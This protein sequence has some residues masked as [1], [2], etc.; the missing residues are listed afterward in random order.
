MTGTTMKNRTRAGDVAAAP[1]TLQVAT[2]LARAGQQ[3]QVIAAATTALDAP[4]LAPAERLTLLELRAESRLA[5]IDLA[6][7][8]TDAQAMLALADRRRSAA[9]RARA[10]ACLAHVQTRQERNAEALQTAA[11]ALEAAQRSRRPELIALARLRQATAGF[12]LQPG[13]AAEQATAAAQRFG[14]LGD[15]A[16]QGQALRVLAAVKLAQAD[17]PEHRAIAQQAVDLARASGDRSGES[18]A[19]STLFGGDLDLAQR[20]RGLHLALQAAIA[21]GDRHFEASALHNLCL[22]YNRL[23]LRHRALR[24][25]QLTS[26]MHE[27]RVR[28]AAT[29]NPL[30]IA[31]VLQADLGDAAGCRQ[32][33]AQAEAAD[34]ADPDPRYKGYVDV[35]RARAAERWGTP[36]HSVTLWRRTLAPFKAGWAEPMALALLANAEL[37]AGL[38]AAALRHAARG[39]RLL[40]QR[41][42]QPGGGSE[43]DAHILWQ[44]A[45]ALHANGRPAAAL[46][47][48]EAAYG[49]LVQGITTLSDEGLRRSYLHAPTS[50]AALV[51]A[52][53]A[54]AREQAW[55]PARYTAHLAG[56]AELR[57]SVE[58][59][60]DTGLRLNAL[61]SEA[62]L[63]EFLIEEVAELLGARRV[64]LVLGSGAGAQVAGAQLP[65]DES[66]AALLAAVAP[67]LDEA[68]RTRAIGLR[69]GPEGTDAIEQRS[70]LVAPL[71]V[72]Q[73]LLGFLYA[74]LEGLFGRFHD[75]DRDLL[76]TLAAQAAVALANLRTQEGLERTVAERT[77]QL[78]QRA[79][80]LALINSIQQ[81]LAAKLDFQGIVDLVGDKLCE[82]FKTDD[83]SI[84]WWD[85]EANT[86]ESLYSAE[87]GQHLPKRPPSPVRLGGP[88]EKLLR[89]GVGGYM[90]T[91]EEQ[92][93]KG[94]GGAAPGTD[95]ALSLMAAPI[96]GTQR[97]LG[98]IILEN[99]EREHAYGEA[100]LRVLTTIGA[101]MG[102]ALENARLFDETQRL[103]KETE[104]R[105]AELAVINSIQQAVGAA[106]DFQAIVD[107]VGDKLREVF[108]TGDLS[109]R[110]YDEAAGAV[111]DMYACEH[112]RRL[113]GRVAALKPGT[114]PHRFYTV[115]RQ[116][117]SI[118]SVEEQLARGVPVL[119]GTD[120]A[121]S[122]LVV[123]MLAG[124]RM[125][126]S[127][128]LEDHERDHAFGPAEA[129]L[130][131][132]IAS[133]MAVALL[134]AKS[135]E[136]ERQRAAE[137][138]V[139]NSIQQG[140]AATLDFQGIV[141]LV[142]DKL[143]EVLGTPNVGI[144]WHDQNSG[145]IHYL[146]EREQAR[147]IEHPPA[148]PTPGGIFETMMR[149]RQPVVFARADDGG[150]VQ[151]P[152]LAGTTTGGSSAHMPIIVG[153][154]VCGAISCT[155]YERD[156]AFCKTW[157]AISRDRDTFLAWMKQHVLGTRDHAQFMKSAGVRR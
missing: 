58:R 67:W 135:F 126:G 50:H 69:H 116:T 36:R 134:N 47:A 7:A 95:W 101:T 13:A 137:L 15:A 93:A 54:H 8:E 83:L 20:L 4:G 33:L 141:T 74:D 9:E 56:V 28:P 115:D 148:P 66:A 99:H 157:D 42:G 80:E 102:T 143:C 3:E 38:P 35:G 12:L 6:G 11:A 52:W 87:H 39:A 51:Q 136:A 92:V 156:N 147:R 106:L 111:H 151:A 131:S 63:H 25:I 77:A 10:L 27:G 49:L 125:L 24:L 17:T 65:D 104:A 44:H 84:R 121:R 113:P 145:L 107:T 120:R 155:N 48:N 19:L 123:P 96:Q 139:I 124:E 75:T 85:A 146:Y 14:A 21:G 108:A 78:E 142:G 109:I 2:D 64:L 61:T 57:E 53:V 144:R 60:V 118:G 154:R 31:V 68:G 32:S 89:T 112:G 16:H 71:I 73:E 119:A 132:T 149:T 46:Q 82:V 34:A 41:L 37:R 26:A 105:N 100:D 128:H 59:L 91:R 45:R 110:W 76:A 153:D 29:V 5:L 152:T 129:R 70:C 88:A 1:P 130:V 97:V 30:I 40:R 140:I 55:P 62:A 22:A 79:G 90:G 43:S 103:L 117:V 150:V 72:K 114:I 23:G 18:R 98:Y 138:A 133:S 94:I 86:L 81:G 122:L 127:V